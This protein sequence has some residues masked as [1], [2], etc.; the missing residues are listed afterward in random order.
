MTKRIQYWRF[1]LATVLVCLPLQVSAEDGAAAPENAH[2]VPIE[3]ELPEAF[4][5]GTPVDYWGPT[6]EPEDYRDPPPFLA[7]EGVS[8][9][10]AGKP[11]T[12]SKPP[13]HG[14]L[15]QVND[16]DKHYARSSLVELPEGL[17][18]V[19]ID[20][21]KEHDIYAV[22]VW[23]FHEGKQVYFDIVARVSN[24]KEF[25]DGVITVYNNDH[26]NSSG[27][28]VGKDN[29]YIETNRGRLIDAKGVSGRYLRLYSNGNTGNEFNHYV[30]VEVYGLPRAS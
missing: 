30:E 18:W 20:L 28:G 25:K 17:Q 15:K 12:S 16:G 7:P 4:T 3:I 14:E 29:E 24:D 6:L 13:L 1:V 22:A 27:L 19:Q 9:V 2:L 11:V 5:G 10:A 8:N 21:G 23:H 26:D